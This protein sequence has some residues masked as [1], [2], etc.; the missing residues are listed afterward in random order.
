MAV[1]GTPK[2]ISMIILIISLLIISGCGGQKNKDTEGRMGELKDAHWITDARVWPEN[3]AD[4]YGDLPAPLFR[5]E[6]TVKKE[7][8]SAVLYIT[9]AG[10]YTAFVNG[11]KTG[12]N[13]L[14]PAWTDYSKR[15]YYTEYDITTDLKEGLNCIGTTLGNGFYNPLPLRM[16]GRRNMREELPV[17]KPA[18]I[19]R[20]VIEY[21]SGEKEEIISD[22]SWSHSYGAIRK[23]NV[24]TGEVYDG[25][26]ES[27]GWNLADYNDSAWEPAVISDGPAGKLQKAYFPPIRV[28]DTIIPVAVKSPSE[29][30]YVMDM[31]VNFTGLYRIKMRGQKGD[32][33]TF[34]F[35]ERLFDNGELNPM[36]Q[37]CGQIKSKGMGGPGAPDIAWQ[38]D[39]YIFGDKQEVWYTPTY[40]YHI[41]RYMEV[42]GL[43]YKPDITDA[44][45]IA[46]NTNVETT[47]S[48]ASSSGL[49]NSIQNATRLTFLD[50]LVSVQSDCPGREKFGYGGDLNATSESFIFNFDMQSFYRKTVYDWVD[51]MNDTSFIDTAPFVGIV[52]CGI[53]WES[54]FLITQYKLLLYYNDIGLIKELYDLDLKWME[55]AARLHPEGIVKSGLAD[56]EALQNVPVELIG[57]THYLDCARIMA[58]FAAIMND[59]ENENRFSRLAQKLEGIMLDRYWNNPV[60][61]TINKQT[62][63]ATLL[64]YDILP[65]SERAAAA[66]S[67]MAA[68]KKAP[69]GHFT[70][71]IF[72]TKYI[73]E[74]L[75]AGGK[76][77]D[78]FTVVNSTEYPGW[79]HMID[80][81]ATTIWET[82]KESDNV[83]S[84]CHPMFGTVSEWYFR[85][86]GGIQPD[87][88]HPGFARFNLFPNIPDG[89]DYIKCSYSSP[90]GTI[91]SNWEKKGADHQVYEIT[92]PD[93]TLA[94]VRITMNDNQ[95]VKITREQ[96]PDYEPVHEDEAANRFRLKPG[97]YLIS[98]EPLN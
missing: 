24:Y 76:V 93:G 44:E 78:V 67:V 21:K 13:Y 86:L 31:G 32:T 79:G 56:H 38:T 26:Y 33:V 39:T 28:T 42:T 87:A 58:R 66:D 60:P 12:R 80:R 14:D 49:L 88:D 35:G 45:G 94:S 9:A 82:W 65:E 4:M 1:R 52:Y 17:G 40:T 63:F 62:V 2:I 29:G 57:T 48:F 7:I 22:H 69:A 84:N 61:D 20:L 37:V 23:N 51:A 90:F 3:D 95:S 36:T 19:A 71:G 72:G 10:Y 89:L 41:F 5:K 15:I 11:Q 25:N 53:S 16:W 59:P 18:F 91:V 34:R 92:V 55:K 73:L 85:W 6:F 47:G 96:E 83:Y 8:R 97:K 70:T 27:D 74:A 50:N 46:L 81:G 75:S 77:N 64:Y 98:A 30:K 68:V 43:K 54:A